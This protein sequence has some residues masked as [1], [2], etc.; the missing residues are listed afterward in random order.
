VEPAR[1]L[2]TVILAIVIVMLVAVLVADW[3]EHRR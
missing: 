3:L 1:A 2:W